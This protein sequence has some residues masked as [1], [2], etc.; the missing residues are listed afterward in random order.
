MP[1]RID[2]LVGVL[3]QFCAG[4]GLLDRVVPHE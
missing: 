2:D 1:T 4:S 3:G